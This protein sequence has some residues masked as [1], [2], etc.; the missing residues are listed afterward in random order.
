MLGGTTA[1]IVGDYL[2]T[3]RPATADLDLLQDL[4]MSIKALGQ[5]L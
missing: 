5:A 2:T 1:L 4:Q 3:L